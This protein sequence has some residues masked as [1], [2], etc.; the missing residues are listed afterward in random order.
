MTD[1][2]VAE[3]NILVVGGGPAA[4]RFVRSFL[5]ENQTDRITVLSEE[6]HVPYDRVAL[7]KLFK[8]P[9]K[10]LTL[11]NPE[12]WDSPQVTLV[13][14]V[15]GE[16]IN[17]TAR[18]VTASNQADYPYDEL[19]LATGSRA[20]TIPIPGSEKSHVFRTIEDVQG[21]VSEVARLKNQL[22]RAP[23]AIVVGGGLL[24]L[25]AA[26]GLRDLGAEPTIL[27][28]AP[29][30]LSIE[31]DE[32]GGHLVNA[33]IREAGIEIET[34]AFIS[35]VNLDSSGAVTSVSVADGMGDEA[36]VT[37]IPADL[38][39]M[40]AGI[41]PNDLI[42]READ[43]EI[44]ERGGVLVT[45]RCRSVTDEKIW[46]IG[47][48]ACVLGRVWGLVAPA[49]Q[50]ADAV[51]KN[52]NGGDEYVEEF[53]IATKLKFSG[54]EVGGFGDRRGATPG[55]L[56]ISY[57]DPAKKIYQKI[58]VSADAKTLLGGVFVGDASPF[59]ALKPLLGRELP[60]DPSAYLSS[61]GGEGAP[62]TE[63]PDDAILCPCNN[64]SFGEIRQ[65]IADGNQDVPSIK[66]ATTA[67][68]QCGSCVPMI[69]KTLV[70]QMK[71]MGM[72]V[73]KALCEHFELSRA[74]LF[75]AVRAV[76]KLDDF[77]SVLD[78]FG[79]GEDGCAICKPTVASILASTR[80]SYALD[81]GRGTLQDTN[82]RN[83]ANMQKDGTYGIIPRIPGGE[84]TPAKLAAIAEVAGEYGLYT[85]INGAQRIGMYGARLEQLPEIWKKLVDAGFESGQAYGK[86]LRNVKSCI[87]SAW[88]RFGVQD[89]VSM[90]VDTE[91]RYKGLRSPHKFK[92]AVSG[93]NRECAE[94]Q[95]K[96]VGL[97]ATTNG[98]NLYFAGN[99]GANPAHGRLFAQDLDQA[100]AYKY[101]DRYLMYYIRTADKLQRTARW[102]E[103]LDEKFGD[104]IEHLR[105]VIIDDS[106]G[107][108]ADLDADMQYHIDHYEDEW[109]ATLNDPE[110]L[111]R[112]R[113]FVN[114]P[115]VADDASRLYVLE[116]NQIRPAT[117]EE[118][119]A[120][121][122]EEEHAPVLIT[123]AKIPVGA[124]A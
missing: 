84:I 12:I 60:A 5:A 67:G 18:T 14:G 20:S 15:R 70:Q 69:Q 48:V 24:G 80:K 81:G 37:E 23:K 117:R 98:W 123:G 13:R 11:A 78:R 16:K 109:A 58:V 94:A 96:D 64:I 44:G 50:M 34:G 86:S 75:E 38:V 29:W 82:D 73:S 91:N 88:C 63:L 101:I 124:P 55:A 103:D 59:D 85:K 100:T 106:L 21:M 120:A 8:E 57:N 114:Q 89:S 53:D 119:A 56:E 79:T 52:L 62:D 19:V 61:A 45:D 33:L 40:A 6:D 105:A 36:A 107:I 43:L 87:G 68:T 112:F 76:G 32:G 39:C 49:N 9:T 93:C 3:R 77:Y 65:S 92:V 72:S 27:D 111:K 108:C 17:R 25:E 54:L 102:A 31:V 46:A 74:E 104:A 42:A 4:W 90:A 30:L 71:K 35:T 2:N 122:A 26:E 97:I 95:G 1:T 22:G 28:V 47:E 113:S 116:R 99:G 110:R 118:L 115:E 51:A 121:E 83:L 66:G 10:D 7:E 41:R